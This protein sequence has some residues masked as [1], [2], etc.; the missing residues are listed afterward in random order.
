MTSQE[1]TTN[2][3]FNI[4]KQLAK[5]LH[6]NINIKG[7]NFLQDEIFNFIRNSGKHQVVLQEHK[8]ALFQKEN[9]TNRRKNHKVDIFIEDENTVTA[10]NSKGKSFNNTKSEDSELKEY[11]WY[12]DSLKILYPT[13]EC[14][15]YIFKDEYNPL[16]TKMGVYHYLDKNGIKVFNT[17]NYLIE[18]YGCDFTEIENNRQNRAVYEC[19]K[20]LREENFDVNK[21]YNIHVNEGNEEELNVTSS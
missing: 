18:H 19:E 1:M 8:I 5:I 21:L 16:D 7:G 15:Y 20:Y 4:M 17:E 13:K 14:K 10:I 6:A 11:Q 3:K 9:E 12:L 2:H